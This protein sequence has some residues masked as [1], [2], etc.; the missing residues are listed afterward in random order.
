MDL[1]AAD[2]PPMNFEGRTRVHTSV[3]LSVSMMV[4][5][6]CGVYGFVKFRD[7]Y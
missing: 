7:L 5:M 3:G 6:A 1:F 4:Y 2:M